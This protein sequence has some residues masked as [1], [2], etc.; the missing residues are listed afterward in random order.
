MPS[1]YQFSVHR[2]EHDILLDQSKIAMPSD[3]LEVLNDFAA[4]LDRE[5]FFGIH[6]N[7]LNEVIGY[8][9]VAI[10]GASSVEVHPREFFRSAILSG[11]SFVIAAHNHPSGNVRLSASD[12][13]LATQL[14]N[15]GEVL[16]I[17]VVDFVVL[18]GKGKYRSLAELVGY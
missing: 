6:L 10:G 16:G 17:P 5:N 14:R 1:I 11:A 13:E 2:E 9:V 4:S 8:E 12:I 3:I 15:S 18:G 7:A